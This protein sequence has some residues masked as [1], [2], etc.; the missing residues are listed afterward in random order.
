MAAAADVHPDLLKN[1]KRFA[2]AG[3]FSPS[4]AYYMAPTGAKRSKNLQAAIYAHL[5][6][7]TPMATPMGG[8]TPTKQLA[9]KRARR[10]VQPPEPVRREP[11]DRK[12]K[13]KKTKKP[14]KA[15]PRAWDGNRRDPPDREGGGAGS[16]MAVQG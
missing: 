4:I 13:K 5:V 2:A 3:L 10:P 1:V 9:T 12:K 15:K 16:A 7:S 6:P 11:G 8:K 14:E